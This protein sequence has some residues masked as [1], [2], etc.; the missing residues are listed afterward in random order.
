MLRLLRK[1]DDLD[2]AIHFALRPILDMALTEEE[3]ILTREDVVEI[4]QTLPRTNL[5]QVPGFFSTSHASLRYGDP[6]RRSCSY[7]FHG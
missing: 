2:T 6:Q 5:I 7:Q 1:T 4:I 3:N